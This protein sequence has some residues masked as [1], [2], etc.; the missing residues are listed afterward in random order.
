MV[1]KCTR[2]M[3]L[4]IAVG[5][6][7]FSGSSQ[8]V[9]D[10]LSV[11]RVGNGTTVLG[12]AAAPVSILQFNTV[13]TGQIPSF[14][15]NL[16][17]IVNTGVG[18]RAL[19][20]SGSSVSEGDISLSSDGRYLVFTGY[21]AAPGTLSVSSGTDEAVVAKV[22]AAGQFSTATSYNRA[23]SYP[24]T[25]I[26]AACSV[27]GNFFWTSGSRG[28]G[29]SSLRLIKADS[30]KA[31][32]LPLTDTAISTRT[33]NIFDGQLYASM[34][35]GQF[36]LAAIGT[37]IPSDSDQAVIN[38]PGIP[39]SN[40][41]PYAF[42]FLDMNAAE[43][44]LDVLYICSMG[45]TDTSGVFKY[46]K[47]S[48]VWS[49]NGYIAGQARGIAAR[50]LCGN[51]VELYITSATSSSKR[52]TELYSFE[53]ATGYRGS[54]G[55]GTVLLSS[56]KVLARAG[57][58]YA[59]GGVSF[60]PGT[61]NA[62]L[63][64]QFCYSPSR[65]ILGVLGKGGTAPYT[66]S[67]DGISYQ[68]PNALNNTARGYTNKAPGS[69]TV[70]I[71]DAKGCIVQRTLNTTTLPDC[72]AG[73]PAKPLQLNAR[74]SGSSFMVS[75][76]SDAQEPVI[77]SVYDLNGTLKFEQKGSAQTVFSFGDT[78]KNGVYA[79]RARQG[80]QEASIKVMK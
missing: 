18:N 76:I 6:F 36:R 77:L 80:N 5:V 23:L 1:I 70:Y 24:G 79:V 41:D 19:T 17:I 9:K 25:S 59:F 64:G 74:Q 31:T 28:Q 14:L 62:A 55:N 21:N 20:Q 42:Y 8:F 57:N 39:T 50:I 35:S 72:P 13:D 53:D 52:P 60:T 29:K 3:L 43:P 34:N 11:L 68:K 33:I 7:H 45:S 49:R 48:G 56:G 4:L 30:S 27:D 66:Y 78:F 22:N 38:L 65:S 73:E 26:R 67:L 44:G 37:G 10:Q 12:S 75:V 16:P 61:T 69:Y 32:G 46:S 47:K 58:N 54:I 63:S 15:L 40:F 51:R 2:L 71:K